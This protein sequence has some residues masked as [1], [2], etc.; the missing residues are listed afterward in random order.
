MVVTSCRLSRWRLTTCKQLTINKERI[1]ERQGAPARVKRD[2]GRVDTF[3][4]SVAVCR[5]DA[6]RCVAVRHLV[7]ADAAAAAAADA[8]SEA[9]CPRCWTDIRQVQARCMIIPCSDWLQCRHSLTACSWSVTGRL[10][11]P[12]LS[13]TAVFARVHLYNTLSTWRLAIRAQIRK[14]CGFRGYRSLA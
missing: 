11:T 13:F 3:S 14:N 2:S 10:H 1:D 6:T 4:H 5:L 9:N 12:D 8:E 7:G